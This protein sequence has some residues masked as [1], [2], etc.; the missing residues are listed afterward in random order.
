MRAVTLSNAATDLLD[1]DVNIPIG[2]TVVVTGGNGLILQGAEDEAFTS[3]V[4]LATLTTAAPFQTVNLT[5][6]YVRVSTAAPLSLL[7]N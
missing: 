4:T 7:T 2:A 5:N 1:T 6:R 3:P